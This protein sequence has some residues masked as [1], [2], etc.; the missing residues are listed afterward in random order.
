[1]YRHLKN[2]TTM[3]R[4]YILAMMAAAS[5]AALAQD[6]TDAE[7]F[8]R[9]E[10]YGSAR[11]QAMGGAF[12]ALGADFTSA[13][14]NPAGIGVYRASEFGMTLGVNTNNI[15]STTPKDMGPREDRGTYVSG[16]QFGVVFSSQR[17]RQ[18]SGIAG[19]SFALSYTKT[20]DYDRMFTLKNGNMKNS[21][22]DFFVGDERA[23][24]AYEADLAWDAEMLFGSYF[25]T[26]P[27]TGE[28]YE[29]V[30]DH[31]GWEYPY[32]SDD[33]SEIYFDYDM[34][35]E[36]GSNQGKISGYRHFKDK[37]SK[38][39]I[40][41]AYSQNIANKVFWGVNMGIESYSFKRELTHKEF[42]SGTPEYECPNNFNYTADLKQDG[43]GI[44][45][46]GGVIYVPMPAL[47]LGVAVHSPTFIKIDE[48]YETSFQAGTEERKWSPYSEVEYKFTAPARMVL[49][50][51]GVFGTLGILSVDYE[52]MGYAAAKFRNSDEPGEDDFYDGLNE[53]LKSSLKNV[54][55][56]RIGAEIKPI[57]MLALRAGVNVQSTPYKNRIL[58]Y[59][60]QNRSITGGVGLRFNNFFVDFSYVNNKLVDEQW[61]L[62]DSGSYI[63]ESV[64]MGSKVEK[65]SH[66]VSVS[67]GYRF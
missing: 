30:I 33:L 18:E 10:S 64:D 35:R 50:A 21:L 16:N 59:D 58:S 49:S 57:S 26:D 48:T 63:Y 27:E 39:Q 51:A 19:H 41:F 60:Y 14:I 12:G 44:T 29:V 7:R 31:N 3:K 6:Y 52:L 40:S 37:G 2:L 11:S 23:N 1:M 61:L 43:T 5:V 47:R 53:G 20:A 45:F 55:K 62:P 32:E 56:L 67:V 8:S 36:L 42:Y 13:Q 15:V 25:D 66:N 4:Y 65:T 22:L 46:G 38:G 28:E 9:I 34:R 24:N 17:I 54:H